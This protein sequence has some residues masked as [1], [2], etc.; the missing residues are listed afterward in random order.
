MENLGL[1]VILVCII[2]AAFVLIPRISGV[3]PSDDDRSPNT[4]PNIDVASGTGQTGGQTF[5]KSPYERREAQVMA[6]DYSREDASDYQSDYQTEE[7]DYFRDDV[8]GS[9]NRP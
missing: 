8:P 3:R 1:L 5:T 7:P 2:L 6:N 4:T 9:E